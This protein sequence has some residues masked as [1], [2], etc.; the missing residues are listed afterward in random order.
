HADAAMYHAKR[1][2]KNMF[3]RFEPRMTESTLRR[4]RL[5]E[6]LREALV[7]GES[8]ELAYQPQ[9][10]SDGI[11]I[12]GMEALVRWTHPEFGPVSPAEFIPLAE[13]CGLVVPIG[14][15]VLRNAI[16]QAARWHR[17]GHRGLRMAV[18]MSVRQMGD[19]DLLSLLDEVLAQTQLPPS[20]LEF[21]ITESLLLEDAE[22]NIR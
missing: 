11:T 1:R 3:Q 22:A 12:E 8:L 5:Q 4:L 20:A 16:A 19:G 9:F 2:G 10:G 6:D 15:W 18:N 13:D 21:E 7:T 14:H 17:A